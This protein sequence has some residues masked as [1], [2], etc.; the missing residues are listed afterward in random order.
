MWGVFSI[1][2][3]PN[4]LCM[5][6]LSKSKDLS[7]VPMEEMKMIILAR[8]RVVVLMTQQNLTLLMKH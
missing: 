3:N 4:Y 1:G 6:D 7:L 5:S 2:Y 8:G